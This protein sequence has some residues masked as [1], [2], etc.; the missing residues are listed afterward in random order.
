MKNLIANLRILIRHKKFK[1]VMILYI[2]FNL[3]ILLTLYG[4]ILYSPSLIPDTKDLT[5]E[6]A[7]LEIINLSRGALISQDFELDEYNIGFDMINF[8]G[9][10]LIIGMLFHNSVL[11]SRT[12]KKNAGRRFKV[13]KLRKK[14]SLQG[15]ILEWLCLVVFSFAFF[16]F[17]HNIFVYIIITSFIIGVI[18]FTI[19]KFQSTD[20]L[21]K[22]IYS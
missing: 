6:G 2:L 9:I 12:I 14:G 22:P 5:P 18:G 3:G 20:L 7:R 19:R 10:F 15:N 16:T 8:G 13:Y 11:A 21:S 4:T 17:L 1:E